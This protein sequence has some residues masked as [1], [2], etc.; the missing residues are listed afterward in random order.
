MENEFDVGKRIL[1]PFSFEKNFHRGYSWTM[2]LA[3]RMNATPLFFTVVP[4]HQEDPNLQGNVYHSL[5]EA[6]G[7]YLQYFR[8]S[9]KKS[10][11]IPKTERLIE[12][13]D[14]TWSLIKFV[15][16]TKFDIIVVDLQASELS[17]TTLQDVVEH[18]NGV[19]VLPDE[20]ESLDHPLTGPSK[21][22][23]KKIKQDFYDI[24]EQSDLYKV[25]ANF[26]RTL[27]RDRRLFNYLR[28][29]FTKNRKPR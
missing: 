5:L 20:K 2:E 1:F 19:I 3:S 15:K 24:L 12:K 9:N 4:A 6:R 16:K 25:P 18:A 29:F 8:F 27:G 13:G 7:N 22:I 23:E 10:R 17:P 21:A 11:S 28:G 26:F 14:F